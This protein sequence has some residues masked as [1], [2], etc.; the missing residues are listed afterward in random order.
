MN[1]KHKLSK[2][3]NRPLNSTKA[4][5]LWAHTY[6]SDDDNLVF[7]FDNEI[8]DSFLNDLNLFGKIILD[9]GCGTGRNWQRLLNH[10]PKKIIGC[11][12]SGNMLTKLKN[13]FPGAETYLIN[14]EFPS[15][16]LKPC[17]LIISTLVAAQVKNMEKLLAYWA[18]LL[19]QDGK[20]IITDLHPAILSAGG[21]RTFIVN[22]KT[23]E[24]KNYIHTIEDIEKI[25]T[26]L[27]LKIIQK[28]GKNVTEEVKGFYARK[29]ALHVYE[30]FKGLPLVYGLKIKH[31]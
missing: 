24:V 21:K 7:K 6:D 9:Y 28:M 20:I 15:F 27:N 22:G 8:L 19:K 29:N 5:N 17:D 30:K 13:K 16:N 26:D 1:L 14:G 4:Y 18:N 31:V 3:I 25:C 2:T 23:R 12:S 11:D 10:Q